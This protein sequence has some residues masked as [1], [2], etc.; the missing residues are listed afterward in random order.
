MVY[1]KCYDIVGSIKGKFN[2][3]VCLAKKNKLIFSL[4]LK[5]LWE[6]KIYVYKMQ[7]KN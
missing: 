2:I 3:M 7:L 5:N 4:S 1:L 6:M